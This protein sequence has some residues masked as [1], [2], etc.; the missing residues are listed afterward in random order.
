MGETVERLLA[1]LKCG[2]Q[3]LHAERLRVSIF[4]A[5]MP[6]GKQNTNPI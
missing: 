6:V 5:P 1:E 2:L 3:G 4:T